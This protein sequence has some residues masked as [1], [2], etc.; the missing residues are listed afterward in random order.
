MQK[1]L[2]KREH[3]SASEE[4]NNC[5]FASNP[6]KSILQYPVALHAAVSGRHITAA[7]TTLHQIDRHFLSAIPA[8][9]V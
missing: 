9:S 6:M 2:Y 3:I 1:F 8:Y 5:H 4:L 7:F